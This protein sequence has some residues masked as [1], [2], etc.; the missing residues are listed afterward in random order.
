[1]T[2]QNNKAG[3]IEEIQKIL[4][5]AEEKKF[6]AG[7]TIFNEGDEDP[8]FYI[9][10]SGEVEISK[11]TTE[12]ES[13]VIAQVETGEF[14]GEGVLSGKV[15]KPAT[16]KILTDV[17]AM[18]L[19]MEKFKKLTQEESDTAV[20]FLLLVLESAN[21]RLVQTN[22]KLMAIYEMSELTDMYG[23]DLQN[24][25]SNLIE[26]LITIT[27]SKKGLLLLKNPFADTYRTV[28]TSSPD[29]NESTLGEYELGKTQ[30]VSNEKGQ[31]LIV[32][33]KDLGSIV[34]MRNADV[35]EYDPY[36][37]RLLM[38]VADLVANNIKE[39]SDRA[40]DKAEKLLH[41]RTV[42]F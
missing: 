32:D 4:T 27:E 26:K 39:A 36:H 37:M 13:K 12:G 33:L 10:L 6:K 1:M 8:N 16:A 20:K 42:G 24:L 34:L 30:K 11:K 31:F 9:I 17:V 38:L 28:Y 19:S 41:R 18:A 29:L 40:S 15:K 35:P 25:A 22:T 7:E 21:S 23:D 5:I 14:L 3:F 2:N